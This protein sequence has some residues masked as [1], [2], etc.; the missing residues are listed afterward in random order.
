[1]I[2]RAIEQKGLY[3]YFL[4]EYTQAKKII[5]DGINNEGWKFLDYIPDE[6]TQSK[7]GQEM[8][9]ELKNGSILRLIGTDKYDSIRGTNPVGCVFSEYAF[10]N[11]MAWEV[12]RPILKVNGGWAVFN[13]TPNG[14]NHAYELWEM[15]KMNDNWYTQML[16]IQ[17][18]G[19]LDLQDME[20]ER[21]EGMSE[22]MIQQE[23][24]C[25]FD[26]GTLGNYYAKHIADA[27]KDNRICAVPYDKTFTVDLSLDLGKN[28]ST[29][30]IFTQQVGKEIRIIDFIED[31]GKDISDYVE[32][33]RDKDYAYRYMWLPHDAFNARLESPKTIADQFKEAGFEV[34]RL[35]KSPINNGIQQVRKIFPRLWFDKTNCKQLVRALE[36]YHKEYDERAKVFKNIPKH[37]WS[38]HSADAMRYM[39]IGLQEQEPKSSDYERA[40][41]EFAKVG[42]KTT[43]PHL[44]V[45]RSE[46]ADYKSAMY[47]FINE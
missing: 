32:M 42:T 38:S 24:Y 15:A 10:Q 39:A 29:A 34:R 8:K 18:T 36:N 20:D 47:D 7:N 37:D 30:I 46:Y 35:L 33:L 14:K 28:D 40:A 44:G 6:I 5:W 9:V 2:K 4:P 41:S 16:T 22:E 13:T 26:I 19:V 31:T 17:D 21:K 12:V 27:H 23:Y 1:M 3:F 45:H 43:D 11:P 25:S